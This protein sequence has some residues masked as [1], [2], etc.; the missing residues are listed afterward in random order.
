MAKLTYFV[1]PL[2][3]GELALKVVAAFKEICP[4]HTVQQFSLSTNIGGISLGKQIT[5]HDFA[6]HAEFKAAVGNQL[7]RPYVEVNSASI[8]N[9]GS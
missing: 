2:R 7:S 4:G 9:R 5:V 3:A 6:D 8:M 1:E